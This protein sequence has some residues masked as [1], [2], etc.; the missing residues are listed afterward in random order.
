LESPQ[1]AAAVSDFL[2]RLHSPWLGR[3]N[4]NAEPFLAFDGHLP[5]VS[6]SKRLQDGETE[7]RSTRGLRIGFSLVVNFFEKLFGNSRAIVADP[8][9]NGM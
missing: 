2:G 8:A 3:I 4:R 5:T 6:L 1:G 7:A 9:L